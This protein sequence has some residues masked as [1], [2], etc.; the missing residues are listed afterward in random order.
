M[1]LPPALV[2]ASTLLCS[3]QPCPLQAF[4][5]LHE[6]LAL[7]QALWPL[8]ELMPAHFTASALAG[9]GAEEMAPPINSAAAAA[10]KV[11][12]VILRMELIFVSDLRFWCISGGRSDKEVQAIS[13]PSLSR[14]HQ[15]VPPG[16]PSLH[17]SHREPS[18]RAVVPLARLAFR[19][20]NKT[21]PCQDKELVERIIAPKEVR[22]PHC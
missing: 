4:N 11:V 6:L 20:C 19:P 21:F 8:Q 3:I 7:L 17:S 15:S 18:R 5:P 22:K 12:P 1:T 16:G 2:Q 9:V 14:L 13:S 10:A